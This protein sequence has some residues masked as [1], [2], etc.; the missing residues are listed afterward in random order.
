MKITCLCENTS[1]DEC[2]LSE[3]GLSLL[4]E[5][6][7]RRIL[8]DMG[9][10]DVFLKNA[11]ALDVDLS[12]VDIAIVSHGHYDH[13]GGLGAFLEINKSAKIYL[14]KNAFG[15]FYNK[16][17]KYIGSDEKLKNLSRL[18]FVDD[19]LKLSENIELFSCNKKEK[20]YP[21]DSAGLSI[22]CDGKILPDVFEHEIYLKIVEGSKSYLISGCSHKGILNICEWFSPDTLV[23]G[24]HFKDIAPDSP[25][26]LKQAEQLLKHHTV[27]YTCHCTGE[28]QYKV[29][30][31]KMGE[32][33]HYL[34]SG[35]TINL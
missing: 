13:S 10:T 3:H 25:S 18:E 8:F 21:L 27:Y 9:Q 7:N 31:A 16:S 2:F 28:E 4:I 12:K 35:K 30:K 23:G 11:E 34:R 24:F 26:L 1:F 5:T 17:G 20:K 6:D 29:L 32:K 22:D 19:Y 33:L 15:K 14:S